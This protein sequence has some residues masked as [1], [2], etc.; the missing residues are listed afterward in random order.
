MF[1][2]KQTID[3]LLVKHIEVRT[4]W[5]VVGWVIIGLQGHFVH[6]D[7][8][9]QEMQSVYVMIY[10]GFEVESLDL[11]QKC[12][13]KYS[14]L[15][16]KIGVV[17]FDDTLYLILYWSRQAKGCYTVQ[18]A[19]VKLS[20]SWYFFSISLGNSFFMLAFLIKGHGYHSQNMLFVRASYL[21]FKFPY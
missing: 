6:F 8:E 7:S 5:P 12:I 21:K 18:C 11:Y 9:F 19:L 10:Y 3:R 15:I 16:L 13:F 4:K 17:D 2:D 1:H 20:K 14:Q